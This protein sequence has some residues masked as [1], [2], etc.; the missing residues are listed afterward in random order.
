MHSLSNAKSVYYALMSL[1]MEYNWFSQYYF[2]KLH[3]QQLKIPVH[4]LLGHFLS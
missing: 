1:G 2:L 4:S 3:Y